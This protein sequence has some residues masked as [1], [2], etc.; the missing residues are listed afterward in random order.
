LLDD[1]FI[2]FLRA[3]D[4]QRQYRTGIDTVVKEVNQEF[5][6][7]RDALVLDKQRNLELDKWHRNIV[8][9]CIFPFTEAEMVSK[10]GYHFVR[11]S[12][13]HESGVPNFDFLLYNPAKAIAIL[14]EAKGQLNDEGQVVNQ[15]R[16]RMRS[17]I[18]HADYIKNA[19]LN[20][21]SAD[22]DFVLGVQW[23]DANRLA[24]SVAR[25]GGGI[26]VWQSG[27]DLRSGDDRLGILVPGN[28]ERDVVRTM[29]HRDDNLNHEL[30]NVKTSFEYKTFF[31]ESHPVAKLTILNFVD[32]GKPDGV[33][34]FADLLELVRSEIGYVDTQTISKQANLIIELG[35]R[36]GFIK[37]EGAALY[38]LT[39][40]SKKAWNRY[41]E[42][43][44]KWIAWSIDQD[45]G[46]E[47][48]KR[49]L[50]LQGEYRKKREGYQFLD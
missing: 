50:A 21:N 10:V 35:L 31:I 41:E 8:N 28:E 2:E 47:I 5:T 19:Y 43:K 46:L 40:R 3:A 20:S 30:S 24:K 16:E 32:A 48:E 36:I 14:G 25:K 9:S 26:V 37:E 17:A 49:R 33:F 34:S 18:A 7:R 39:S 38:K 1:E 4:L 12:P 23:A 29:M 45:T 42:L 22:Y 15:T 44:Q 11:A 13:L 27:S 6:D